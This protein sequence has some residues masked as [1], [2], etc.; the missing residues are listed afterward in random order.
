MFSNVN[1]VVE[2]VRLATEN[3]YEF[4]IDWHRSC[5]KAQDRH[6]DPWNY[7]F[8][9]PFGVLPVAGKKYKRL[10]TGRPV[11]CTKDNIITPRLRDGDCNPLLLPKDRLAASKLIERYILLNDS[12][13]QVLEKFISESFYPE[14]IGAHIRGRGRRDDGS[15]QLRGLED[16]DE[17]VNLEPYFTA[18][19]TYLAELPE[20]GIL[21]CSDSEEIISQ[22]TKR[23]GERLV[24][25]DATRSEFGE[26]HA[27]H[28]ENAGLKFDPHNLGLDILVE[29]HALARCDAF[30]H[31]NSNIANFVLC[32]APDLKNTYVYEGIDPLIVECK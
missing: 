30:V 2:Q 26:M 19:D 16:I 24:T 6:E 12:T 22:V 3:G 32:R 18:I 23:Y 15:A 17:P 31:G 20:A 5:Y 25:Y 1:E 9:Q 13:K 29:A 11:A 28:P 10:Q 14:M 21:I 8:E 4:Y 27:N 7:Y